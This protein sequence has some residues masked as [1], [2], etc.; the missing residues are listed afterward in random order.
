M[1][2]LEEAPAAPIGARRVN[3]RIFATVFVGLVCISILALH[4]FFSWSVHNKDVEDAQVATN[5]LSRALAEHAEAT[6]TSAD[7]VLFGIVQR[8]EVEGADREALARLYPLLASYAAEL[9]QIQGLF[10]YDHAGKWLV[11][12]MDDSPWML[13]NS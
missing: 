5:N 13:N 2:T 8:L 1:T 10:V 7:A 11:N 4:I 9:P 12:S 3:I 6:L